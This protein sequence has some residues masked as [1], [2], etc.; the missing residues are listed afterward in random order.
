MITYT[1]EKKFTQQSVQGL[2]PSL[3]WVS[4]EYP[5]RL[6][7]ALQNSTT[8]LAAWDGG[9]LAGLVR[10]LEE[11]KNAA[12]Y[13]KHGFRRMDVRGNA[14]L[15]FFGS[16]LGGMQPGGCAGLPFPWRKPLCGLGC[17]GS[18]TGSDKAALYG[19]A[20]LC[21]VGDN[22]KGRVPL[23]VVPGLYLLKWVKKWVYCKTKTQ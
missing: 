19:A 3:G 9:R 5:S 14:A 8:V 10:L 13:E 16:G 23:T 21:G 4:R 2:S 17:G 18:G 15:Y 22:G 11:S 1:D 12:F 7:K 20:C 6:Y